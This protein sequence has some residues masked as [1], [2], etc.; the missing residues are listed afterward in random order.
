LV[1]L[2]F[3]LDT[4]IV[5]EAIRPFPNPAVLDKIEQNKGRA[6]VATVVWHELLFG[7]ERLP[8]SRKRNALEAYLLRVVQAT[9][10]ILPYDQ[11]AAEW[12]A[13]ERARLA[14]A[15]RTPPFLDGQIAATAKAND[16]VLVTANRAHFESFEGLQIEDWRA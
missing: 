9:M 8:P 7:L 4:N 3:L 11:A 15:G 13:R 10:P 6:G 16:L 1:S 2:R 5:S 12:H 14:A